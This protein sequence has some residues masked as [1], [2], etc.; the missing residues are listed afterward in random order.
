[1]N[2]KSENNVIFRKKYENLSIYKTGNMNLDCID[3]DT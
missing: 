3:Y 2:I 1:M